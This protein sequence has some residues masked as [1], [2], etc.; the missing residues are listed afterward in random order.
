[1]RRWRDIGA[2]A[3]LAVLTIVF[4][5]PMIHPGRPRLFIVR[6]DFS[7]QFFPYRWFAAHEW[8]AGRIP[9]WNPYIFAG[10]PFLADIQSAV[11]YPPAFLSAYIGG[12]FHFPYIFVELEVVA[13]TFLAGFFTYVLGRILFQQ[14]LPALV[15]AVLF[16]FSGFITS[17]PAQQLAVLE[18]AVWLPLL[19]VWIELAARQPRRRRT[20]LAAAAVT[21]G[22]AILAGHSQTDL[23]IGYASLGYALVRLHYAG[24]S[25]IWSIGAAVGVGF[26]GL[27]VAGIQIGPTLEFLGYSTRQHMSYLE[28]ASGYRI[29]SLPEVLVPL[30]HGEK[31]LSI[32]IVGFLLAVYGGWVTGRTPVV[33]WGG[34]AIVALILSVGGA[35]PL[36][37]VMYHVAPGWDLFRDQ[38]RSAY[39]YAF[40]G[41]VLAGA[42]VAHLQKNKPQIKTIRCV[43]GALVVAAAVA[44]ALS[45]VRQP[46]AEPGLWTS[47]RIDALALVAGAVLLLVWQSFR[48]LDAVIG[49]A[50]VALV[51]AE[52]F[53]INYGNNLSPVNPDARPALEKTGAFIRQLPE[54][55]RVQGQDDRVFPPNYGALLG[56][57]TIGGDSPFQI[58]RIRDMLAADADWHV[59][60]ILNVKFW[61]SYNGPLAGLTLVFQDGPVKTYRMSDSLPRAWAVR[62]IEVAKTPGQAR[63]MIIAPGYHPGNI[64]VLEKPPAIGPIVPGPRPDVRIT[65]LD[66]Q[67]VEIA[68]RA[69]ANAM[70]VL[71]DTYYPGWQAYRDGQEVPI[72]RA[73]YLAMA[74]TLPPGVHHYVIVYRPTSFYLGAAVTLL[75]IAGLIAVVWLET[76]RQPLAGSSLE[77]RTERVPGS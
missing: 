16:A 43:A 47:L 22:I 54:P 48:R 75:T 1:M 74:M 44:G 55:F 33:Y 4:F 39:L 21:F 26:V 19:V 49:L 28:A 31:A 10:H 25:W 2:T 66:P 15:S 51:T 6:G 11:F 3:A 62:A 76:R 53:S 38:E 35:T 40:G 36:F 8:H 70:L 57:P 37:W 45:V 77:Q 24:E 63:Q 27:L 50:L 18:T 17:Y 64:V 12:F 23:Y 65:H 30:W 42:A 7:Q 58:K 69:D 73:N 34:V 13:H 9:L 56:L 67:R 14:T 59:W 32:G 46:L 71:A 60:Q 5:W 68:A 20:F 41:S 61:I 52:L 29:S 72:Y